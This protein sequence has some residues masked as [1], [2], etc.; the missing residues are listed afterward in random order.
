LTLRKATREAL[1]LDTWTVEDVVI[2]N[3]DV[4]VL[5]RKT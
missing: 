3:N 1:T 5:K 2:L 4:K